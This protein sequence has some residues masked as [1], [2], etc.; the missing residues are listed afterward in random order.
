MIVPG[1]QPLRL[2]VMALVAISVAAAGI[3][4]VY[5]AGYL[6]DAI[7]HLMPSPT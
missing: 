4:C 3:G 6:V 2:A 7:I 5:W 1:K